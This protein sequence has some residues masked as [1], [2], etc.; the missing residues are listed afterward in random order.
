MPARTPSRDVFF[1]SSAEHALLSVEPRSVATF[2]ISD[3]RAR[4]GTKN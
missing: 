1:S 3:H 2:W 4:F